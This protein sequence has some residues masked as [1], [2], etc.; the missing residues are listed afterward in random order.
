MSEREQVH[1]ERSYVLHQR[2]YR[3]TSQLLDCL[4]ERHGLV[5]L[6]A[7]G[8][9]RAYKGQR[10]LLQP[11]LPLRVS[12]VRR[13]ELGRLTHVELEHAAAP[14]AGRSLLAGF[15][16]NELLLRLTARGDPNAEIFSC[17]SRCLSDLMTPSSVA[18][19]LRLFELRLLQAL[20]YAAEL[21]HD[22]DTGEPIQPGLSYRFE[23]E[24]GACVH[25]G[26]GNGD[27]TF[28]GQ[29]L[30]ALREETLADEQSLRAAKRLL[31]RLLNVYLGERPLKTRSVMR[32][33][34][35]RGLET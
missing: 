35:G 34:V 31:A 22:V 30:I 1:L 2:A 12:W 8:S 17:Y 6:V 33:V 32:E 15:Y 4:S 11:F 9:R 26:S 5:T 27:D 25:T 10:A 14:L 13:G 20:G 3:N 18:R 21:G 29:D 16:L 28:L 24:R 7:Q 23:A 19:A